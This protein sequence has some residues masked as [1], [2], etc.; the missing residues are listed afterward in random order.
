MVKK[1]LED[2]PS[3][4]KLLFIYTEKKEAIGYNQPAVIA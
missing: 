2:F 1:G 4:K 3:G